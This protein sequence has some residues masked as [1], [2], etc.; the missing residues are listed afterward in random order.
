MQAA[1]KA[2][3]SRISTML[4]PE[5]E[6][7]QMPFDNPKLAAREANWQQL[8]TKWATYDEPEQ[9]PL[10]ANARLGKRQAAAD[11]EAR[12]AQGKQSKREAAVDTE[13]V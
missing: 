11:T 7:V 6:A 1:P 4:Q 13:V 5:G 12:Q 9:A 10:Q 3:H 2:Q 8:M